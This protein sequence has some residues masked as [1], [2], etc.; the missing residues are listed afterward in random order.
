[1]PSPR[2]D[3]DTTTAR[4][5]SRRCRPYARNACCAVWAGRMLIAAVLAAAI[6]VPAEGKSL[7]DIA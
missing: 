6:G 2:P 3:S 7:E 4:S 1:M 5:V